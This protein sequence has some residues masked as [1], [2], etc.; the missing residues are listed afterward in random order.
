[1]K[2]IYLT[3]ALFVSISLSGVVAAK[4]QTAQPAAPDKP[5]CCQKAEAK[6]KSCHKACCMEA[7]KEGKVCEKCLKKGHKKNGKKAESA[8]EM[9]AK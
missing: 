4:A 3:I 2:Q 7:A 1:M 9:P 8:E 6:G 5:A